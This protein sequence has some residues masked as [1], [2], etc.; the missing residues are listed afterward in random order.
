[1]TVNGKKVSVAGLFAQYYRPH[2]GLFAA[3]LAAAL[4]LAACD[5]VY[6][7]LTRS[8]IND[9]VPNRLFSALLAACAVLLG[10]FILKYFLNYF[11]TSW[12]HIM[13]TRMQADMRRDLFRHMQ[14]LPFSYFDEQKTGSLMSR[15][16]NDLMEISE[17]AHHGPED[18]F[19]SIITFVGGFIILSRINLPLTCI[20]FAFVPPLILFNTLMRKRLSSAFRARRE[21]ISGINAE[22]ENSISGIR[23]AKAFTN[24]EH[25]ERKFTKS[26]G[27]FVK[28]A[29]HSFK[30]LAVYHAGTLLGLDLLT[31]AGLAASAVFFFTGKIN[32]GDFTAFLL[33][34]T[35]FTQPI[36][37][38]TQFVELFE[39]G[40][41]G[42]KRMT[43][44]LA[45]EPEPNPETPESPKVLRGEIEFKNV[46]FTYGDKGDVLNDINLR[47]PA[48]HEVALV[49]P[50]G[51]GKTT[52]CHLIP[53]FYVPQEG[54]ILLDGVDV[55]K[56]DYTELRRAIGIVQQDVFI[57]SGTIAENIGYGD[58]NAGREQVEEAARKA[59]L[60]EFVR[61]L[62]DGYDTDIGERGVK[63]SGGQKQRISIARVFLKNPPILILDEA[64]SSLDNMT[65]KA[66]QDAFDKLSE[67]RTTLVV[68]HRLST[69][70]NADE[71]VVLNEHGVAETG[72]HA[73]LMQM[74]G[75]IYRDLYEMQLK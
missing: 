61:A 10:I 58:L 59:G 38:L 67:N 27:E 46:S 3:D 53:R 12:G 54:V 36:R 35:A 48:G 41:S 22:L 13:G 18:F 20:I 11:V 39:D 66:I 34:I 15:I 52:L 64:T 68:A 73:Q 43:Q 1:M 4:G 14:R 75:G 19:I 32:I 65:E 9:Y 28:A 24:A 37:R 42:F 23:V 60:D 26:T 45:E 8:I 30:V 6:P 74:P 25:E 29:S 72:T 71:I 70:K 49:G 16:V 62:P 17:L 55:Q 57:F 2:V 44:L 31:L 47:I 56:F 5:L 40:M 50:S 21:T 51:G 7:A 69:V 33:Y 63:L